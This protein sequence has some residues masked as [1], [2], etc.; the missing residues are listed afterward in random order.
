MAA[1]YPTVVRK[2]QPHQDGTDY[3]MASHMNTAQDEISAL[4]STLGVKPHI[5]TPA[6]GPTRTYASVAARLTEAQRKIDEQQRT[7]DSL[8]DASRNGW[9]LPVADVF[10]SGT[11]IPATKSD[12]HVGV[13][14]DW[15]KVTWTKKMVDTH[16]MYTRG[17]YVRI[18]KD[19]WYIITSTMSMKNPSA[20]H[21]I[22]HNVWTRVKVLGATPE[23]PVYEIGKGDSS[24]PG[25]SGG[26]HRIVTASGI[27][28]FA[29]DR[30]YLEVRHDFVTSD[31]KPYKQTATAAARCQ[32]TYVRAL[33]DD[34]GNRA[35][36]QLP[37]ELDPNV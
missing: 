33:P 11:P 15:Y 19:G 17:L 14:S 24:N 2:F 35:D 1:N 6:S 30:V 26:W 20:S 13:P 8:L 16:G 29:G 23:S 28:L 27:E 31:N 18:P 12:N 34:I 5:Y 21:S 37:D 36:F 25:N 32:L 10:A 7:I 4:Q 3:V 22:E 9:A